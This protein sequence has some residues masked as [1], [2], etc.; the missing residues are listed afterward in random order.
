LCGHVPE[1]IAPNK[2]LWLKIGIEIDKEEEFLQN[3]L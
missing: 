3:I 2:L 1:I